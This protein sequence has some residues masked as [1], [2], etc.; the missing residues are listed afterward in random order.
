MITFRSQLFFF[1]FYFLMD[2]LI[3]LFAFSPENFSGETNQNSVIPKKK[4]IDIDF[5]SGRL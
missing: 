1:R 4:D 3:S 2:Q 5:W